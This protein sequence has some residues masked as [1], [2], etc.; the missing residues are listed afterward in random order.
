MPQHDS[1]FAGQRVTVMGLGRFG[2]GVGVTRFLVERGADVRV[3]DTAPAEDLA[4]SVAQLDDLPEGSLEY[5]L[6]EHNVS[7]FTKCDLVVANP[8]VRPDNRF[9]RAA[10]AA[11]IPVTTEVRLL[12]ERLPNRLKT[13]GVTG[14]A[15]KS[16]VTAMIGHVLEKAEKRKSEKTENQKQ[17]QIAGPQRGPGSAVPRVF[18]GG[19]LGGSLLP[20]LHE[21]TADDWI[22]LELSSFMLHHLRAPE[23]FPA[24]PA[25]A[26][27]AEETFRGRGRGRGWSPHIAVIT[28]LAPNHLDWHGGFEAYRDAKQVIL[29]HQS[30]ADDDAAVGGPGV[31]EHFSPRVT[32]WADFGAAGETWWRVDPPIP[33]LTPGTHNQL[34]ARLAAA[35]LR[36]AIGIDELKTWELLADFPGL[37][38]RLQFVAEHNGVRFFNDSKCT[39]PEAARLALDAFEPGTAH[40]I[41]GGYDK[42]SDLTELARHAAS[43]AAGVY[44]VG[45]T[46]DSVADAAESAKP[47][48][49]VVRCGDLET[50]VREAVTRA[51][52]GQVVLLSPACASWD[53]FENFEQRGNRFVAQVLRWTTETGV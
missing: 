2:G 34:N 10:E 17:A 38:H 26:V 28:N 21:I 25:R 18:L 27:G 35:A 53:Q 33:L 22:V 1:E 13:I 51:E 39:T 19:N 49:A 47:Q 42:G 23:G 30:L 52:P 31:H 8:A 50:A 12:V 37:P 29:D 5:R 20:R 41:L 15:G 44:T 9:L 43:R 48:A 11:G 45:A 3:T 6:G 36:F 32:N 46:G 4:D 7:D 16:T 24:R 14:T 40:L